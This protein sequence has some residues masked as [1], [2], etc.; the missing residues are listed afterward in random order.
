MSVQSRT[1]LCLALLVIAPLPVHAQD[2]TTAE[3]TGPGNPRFVHDGTRIGLEAKGTGWARFDIQAHEP[4]QIRF[5]LSNPIFD[6]LCMFN[7]QGFGIYDQ[8]HHTIVHFYRE[9]RNPFAEQYFIWVGSPHSIMP[10]L[11][12][13]ICGESEPVPLRA[14]ETAHLVIASTVPGF[15]IDLL[16]ASSN[17]TNGNRPL[18]L[19]AHP[20][21]RVHDAEATAVL[22]SATTNGLATAAQEW[23]SIFDGGD[24]T[25]YAIPWM[26]AE[27]DGSLPHETATDIGLY[28]WGFENA[29]HTGRAPLIPMQRGFAEGGDVDWLAVIPGWSTG[30]TVTG[31]VRQNAVAGAYTGTVA[32]GTTFLSVPLA[33]P[34][35]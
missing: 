18:Q 4:A 24:A 5:Q 29:T 34:G 22:A 10:S 33:D 9:G 30:G 12:S 17:E 20:E 31:F 11:Q 32:S 13:G 8:G 21:H 19:E 28:Q 1:I 2:D 16:G 6:H 7:P 35:A 27:E 14:G 3:A 26:H 15:H 25:H 23:R